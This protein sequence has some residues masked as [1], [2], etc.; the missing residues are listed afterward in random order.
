[1]EKTTFKIAFDYVKGVVTTDPTRSHI[2]HILMTST[3]D[4]TTLA[5]TDGHRCHM[6]EIDHG[7]ANEYHCTIDKKK[8]DG[9]LKAID[10]GELDIKS[11]IDFAY[12]DDGSRFPPIDQVDPG[13]R[14]SDDT[15]AGLWAVNPKY[16][17]AA[18]K[19]PSE[20]ALI[21]A[22]EDALGPVV[23]TA[24]LPVEGISFKAIVMPM[25]MR[26]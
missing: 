11:L 22:N 18:L 8:A 25:N 20:R 26:R 21:H 23:V 6:V 10:N 12:V 15:G 14:S 13:L 9:Y 24:E 7:F 3:A 19:T 16:L 1:M 5:A 2:H 17:I 4:K